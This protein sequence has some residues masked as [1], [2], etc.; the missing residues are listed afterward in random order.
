MRVAELPIRDL[1]DLGAT[2]NTLSYA[3]AALERANAIYQGQE[4]VD[5]AKS[6]LGQLGIGFGIIPADTTPA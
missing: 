2:V 4:S 5:Q 6:M 3:A 1:R